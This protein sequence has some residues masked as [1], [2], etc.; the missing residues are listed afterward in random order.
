M[1]PEFRM[2]QKDKASTVKRTCV[3]LSLT[4]KL[5]FGLVSNDILD[6]ISLTRIKDKYGNA[7]MVVTGQF[8]DSADLQVH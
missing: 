1:L 3:L 2:Y 8:E 5:Y 4:L 6:W 7:N